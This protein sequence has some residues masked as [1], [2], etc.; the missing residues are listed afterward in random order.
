MKWLGYKSLADITSVIGG[1][2]IS[3]SGGEYGDA[4]VNLDNPIAG[5]IEIEQGASGGGSALL[6]DNDDVD[7]NALYIDAANT[8][9]D[10]IYINAPTL[11][12]TGHAINVHCSSLSGFSS[13]LYLNVDET[14]TTAV[15]NTLA[16]IDYD[17]AGDLGS[18]VPNTTAGLN[19]SMNDIATGN[20]STSTS[21]LTAL[22]INLDH[23]NTNAL[24]AKQIGIDLTLTDGHTGYVGT[25]PGTTGIDSTVENGGFDIVM[26][27]S[28]DT[29]DH[30]TIATSAAG[31]TTITTV[32]DD[33]AAAHFEIAA[34]GNI[35]LD[36]AGQIKLE[37]VAGNNILLD[38]TVTVDGGSVT[39]I[40]TLG[41]DSVS[42]TAVQTSGESFVDNDTSIMTS[43][44]ID[45]KINTKYSYAY[46][47]WSASGVSSVDGGDPEWIFPNTGKGIYEE[48]WN[49]DENI[50]A[51]TVGTTTYTVTRHSAVNGLV[52]PHTGQ[53][54]GFHAHGR[55]NNNDASFKAGLFHLEGSTTG[56]TNN[57]GI[58]Y[59]TTGTTNECTLRWIATA[60]EAESS[61]GADG[62]SG[63]N[64]KGPCKLVSNTNALTVSAGDVLLPAIMGP[65]DSDEIFVT[66]T[67]ILKM[68]VTLAS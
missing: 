25:T 52:I 17:R 58:D 26:R 51:T 18:G 53:C 3:V 4:T 66:M 32:D 41:V 60:D 37:P 33:G 11:E 2:N 20:H 15:Q 48:D 23:A 54:V 40:T 21:S 6:I 34:D 68:P 67:I 63:H 22:D 56:T 39:G 5:P 62:T 24:L 28:A 55:N 8:T 31:A 35:T 1:T 45:D 10:I 47:T 42:L 9:G 36:S 49:K 43:A 46:M 57:G 27:S 7:K 13:A 12:N 38:G 29:G 64:F 16:Y 59:G 19:I 30:C 65:D 14:S 44:A 50:T 61:G